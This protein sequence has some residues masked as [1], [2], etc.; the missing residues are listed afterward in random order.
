MTRRIAIVG[1]VSHL[2][3]YAFGPAALGWWGGIGFMLIEGMAF[4]LAI[5]VYLYLIPFEQHWPPASPPPDLRYGTAVTL[6]MLASLIPN[7]WLVCRAR[8]KDLLAV[9][10]GLPIMIG[11]GAILLILRAYEF[12]TLNERWD[13]NAYGSI[14]WAILVIHTV[15]LATDVYD[16]C[17]LALLAFVRPFDGRKF[18]D[19]EDNG[20]YWNF[21]AVSWLV[22][23]ALLYWLPR[24]LA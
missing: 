12:T 19:V 11:I 17:P 2:P 15:H 4:V 21:V 20:V 13:A 7:N 1:D 16:S 8:A 3:D 6:L 22:L 24:W 5:G 9:R 10:R 14:V 18:S 23:Y